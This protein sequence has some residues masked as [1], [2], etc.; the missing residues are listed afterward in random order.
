MDLMKFDFI[1]LPPGV[2]AKLGLPEGKSI[3]VTDETRERFGRDVSSI[4]AVV[5]GCE[6]YLAVD[7]DDEDY[8][9]FVGLYYHHK[10]AT[11]ANDGRV[12]EAAELFAKARLLWGADPQVHLDYARA[13]T[14]LERADEAIEGYRAATAAG[15]KSPELYDGLARAF[16][17][18]GD[19]KSAGEV[20]EQSRREFPD[21]L[22]S[23][24]TLTTIRYHQGDKAG[25]EKILFE[26]L[27]RDPSNPLTLEKLSV[28]LRECSRFDEARR[29]I[30][31]AI[32]LA[33]D[34]PRLQYQ[35]GMIE[36][37]SGDFDA[38][39]EAF[40]DVLARDPQNLDARVARA[41]L[42]LDRNQGP[43]AER[44]LREI[45]ALA[46]RDYRAPF[47]LGRLLCRDADRIDQGLR[48]FEQVLDLRPRDRQALHYIY[49]VAKDAGAEG[50]AA[51]A[52][53]Q[54]KAMGESPRKA[55]PE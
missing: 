31:R 43:D 4:E 10:G 47:H 26:Q 23:L 44:R 32:D 41:V 15:A 18:K 20:A 53:V 30:R 39:E 13:S 16:A 2:A 42:A 3:P 36:M 33:P 52:E 46:P 19:F 51:K 8:R 40:D 25:L 22:V 29:A 5:A 34:Q 6:A 28:W 48:F 35:R 50:L 38:A 11:L 37:R 27:A 49:V 54:M 14:E 1:Q 7:P 21:S 24:N 55:E 12:E 45:V 9:K 17:L